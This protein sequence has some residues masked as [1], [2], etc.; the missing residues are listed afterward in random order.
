MCFVTLLS[1]LFSGNNLIPNNKCKALRRHFGHIA[2]I[3]GLDGKD[4]T[5]L[6]ISL[7][8]RGT[9]ELINTACNDEGELPASTEQKESWNGCVRHGPACVEK[10]IC[11]TSLLARQMLQLRVRG[12]LS[13][14]IK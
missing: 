9:H 10:V 12:S 8:Y 11:R 6:S 7:T 14:P 13:F 4:F 3:V 5:Y 1:I 2:T